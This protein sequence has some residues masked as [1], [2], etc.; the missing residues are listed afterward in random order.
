MDFEQPRALWQNVFS[1][2][3]REHYVSNVAGHIKGVKNK[4]ILE[5][6]CKFPSLRPRD[7]KIERAS[8]S[9]ARVRCC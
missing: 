2:T 9:S 4:A 3:V 7:T 1:D 8:T 6:Q 5:R